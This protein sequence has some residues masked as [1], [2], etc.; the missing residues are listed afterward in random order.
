MKTAYIVLLFLFLLTFACKQSTETEPVSDNE[1]PDSSKIVFVSDRPGYSSKQI[2]IMNNDGSDQIKLTNDSNEY[3]HPVFSPDGSKIIFFSHT[4][5]YEDEIYSVNVDG[6]NFMNLSNCGGSD[7]LPAYNQDGSK[8]VF[9]STRDGNR[10]VYIMDADGSNQTRLT[11]CGEI[12]HCPQFIQGGSKILYFS[13]DSN[14]YDYNIHIMDVDGKNN[15]CLNSEFS[16]YCLSSNI[17]DGS[18][19]IYDSR[20]NISPDGS[21][22]IFMSYNYN[23]ANYEI[24]MMDINGENPHLL[25]NI[26]GYNMAPVFFPDGC[27]IIFRSHRENTFDIFTMNL[28]GTQQINLTNGIGH[29]YFADFSN[30]NSKILFYTDKVFYYKIWTMNID[31]SNKTQLTFGEYNDYYPQY[32]PPL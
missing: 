19:S 9:T 10:E 30:N 28:D 21:K 1:I 11:F 3:M 18:F 25:T 20:P 23:L 17:S 15:R 14:F 31:G 8:I 29:A 27:K 12:D 24:F 7:N 16:Y 2:Y 4:V 26:P 22:M 32:Q 6:S 5:N 13:A